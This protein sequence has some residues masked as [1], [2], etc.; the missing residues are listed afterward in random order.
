MRGFESH[1]MHAMIIIIM[2]V[3]IFLVRESNPGRQGENLVSWPSRLTRIYCCVCI[4]I[5]MCVK[6]EGLKPPIAPYLHWYSIYAC[7]III[8]IIYT[9]PA[10]LEPAT[11]RLTAD[12]SANWAMEALLYDNNNNICIYTTPAGFEPARAEPNSLAGCRLNHSA[13]V[14]YYIIV[15]IIIHHTQ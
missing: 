12:R 2:V 15:V 5:I 3:V 6:L 11:Y 4:I 9:L 10:G 7:I 1:R 8:I 14:S 13:K